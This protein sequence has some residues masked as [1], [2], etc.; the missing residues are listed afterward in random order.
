M[1]STLQTVAAGLDFY[2][3]VWL[4]QWFLQVKHHSNTLQFSTNQ[5]PNTSV[6]ITVRRFMQH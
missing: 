3:A 6:P 2:S 1:Q 4:L 5:F